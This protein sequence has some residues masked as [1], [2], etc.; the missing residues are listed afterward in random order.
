MEIAHNAPDDNKSRSPNQQGGRSAT[1]L[2]SRNIRIH[3]RRTSVR[4]E[5]EMWNALREIAMLE[6]CTIHDLCSAIHDTK[7][8]Q[9]SFTAALRVFLM[10]YYRSLAFSESNAGLMKPVTKVARPPEVAAAKE[11]AQG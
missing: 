5:R 11:A 1:T 7:S 10:T 6:K 9:I 2:I 4:L 3:D 8:K